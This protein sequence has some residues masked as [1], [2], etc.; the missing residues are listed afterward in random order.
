MRRAFAGLLPE[1][2]LNRKSKAAYTGIYRSA[3]KPLATDMFKH[4]GTIQVAQRELV[5]LS[6]L[7]SRLEKFLQ[8][9]ED[10]PQL[11]NVILFEYWLR[12]RFRASREAAA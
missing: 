10:E 11:H 12:D 7:L 4:P 9:L 5:A 8:G 2:V 3:L 6:P 1:R